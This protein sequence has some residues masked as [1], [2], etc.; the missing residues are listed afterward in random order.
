[1]GLNLIEALGHELRAWSELMLIAFNF[2]INHS[3]QNIYDYSFPN[4]PNLGST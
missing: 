4:K 3:H 2:R 1:M